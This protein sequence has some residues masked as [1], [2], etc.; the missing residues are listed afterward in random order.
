MDACGWGLQQPLNDGNQ[1]C[2]CL[3]SSGLCSCHEIFPGKGDWDCAALHRRGSVKVV[4]GKSLLQVLRDGEL[5]EFRNQGCLLSSDSR[6]EHRLPMCRRQEQWER[7]NFPSLSQRPRLFCCL[8]IYVE[9]ERRPYSRQ[10]LRLQA[11]TC[12]NVRFEL[13]AINYTTD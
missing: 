1:E 3:T 13:N 2:K 9:L 4:G 12:S 8:R 11:R 6:T 10:E 5:G 7:V